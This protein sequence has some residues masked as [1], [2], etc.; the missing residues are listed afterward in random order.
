LL[1][2]P[3]SSLFHDWFPPSQPDN[4]KSS[5]N[6]HCVVVFGGG[7]YKWNDVLCTYA[8]EFIC[9]SNPA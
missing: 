1:N 5:A 7:G 2:L 8:R 3:G 6:Q 4:G 9:E